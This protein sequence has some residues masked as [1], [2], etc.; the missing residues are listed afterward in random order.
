MSWQA[1]GEG[2]TPA[3]FSRR[4]SA[5]RPTQ[6]GCDACTHAVR[7]PPLQEAK[8]AATVCVVMTITT[9]TSIA[10][11]VASLFICCIHVGGQKSSSIVSHVSL[12]FFVFVR[13]SPSTPIAKL[14]TVPPFSN[15]MA[16]MCLGCAMLC[17]PNR[18]SLLVVRVSLR[19]QNSPLIDVFPQKCYFPLRLNRG[20]TWVS[21]LFF[22]EVPLF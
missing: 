4:A 15:I 8:E 21:P 7:R 2:K 5:D 20:K 6:P 11:L 1:R 14:Q 3:S 13:S 22:D 16:S 17:S 12:F 18:T 9:V 10:C 19:V